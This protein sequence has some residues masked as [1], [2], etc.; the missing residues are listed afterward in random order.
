[1]CT[2]LS[3]TVWVESPET[4]VD[5]PISD[6]DACML[7]LLR[8]GFLPVVWPLGFLPRGFSL[9]GFLPLGTDFSRAV[10]GSDSHLT[11]PLY[12]LEALF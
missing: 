3:A 12:F 4:I 8:L 5:A 10:F 11:V 9:I 6:L 7:G 1:M 2:Q